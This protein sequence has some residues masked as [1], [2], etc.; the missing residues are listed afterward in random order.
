MGTGHLGLVYVTLSVLAEGCKFPGTVSAVRGSGSLS[1]GYLPLGVNAHRE[2]VCS[3]TLMGFRGNV[4][5]ASIA[6][7]AFERLKGVELPLREVE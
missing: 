6:L 2:P 5:R 1:H 4:G 7:L 3:K